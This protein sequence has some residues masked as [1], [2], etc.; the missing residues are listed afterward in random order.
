M[1]ISFYNFATSYMQEIFNPKTNQN[2]KIVP[3]GVVDEWYRRFEEKL[4][5]NPD[6]WKK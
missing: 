2:E 6:F 3:M 1:L 5:N 4:A